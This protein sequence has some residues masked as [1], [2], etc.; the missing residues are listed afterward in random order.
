MGFDKLL[1]KI[2][3]HPNVT[4]AVRGKPVVNDVTLEDANQV[5]MDKDMVVTKLSIS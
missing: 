4:F 5:G 2:M 3:R 1:I